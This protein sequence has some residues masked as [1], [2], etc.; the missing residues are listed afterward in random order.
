E[1]LYVAQGKSGFEAYDAASVGNKGFS[2]PIITAPF[3][4]LGHDTQI[5]TKDATCVALPTNQP[6]H[7]P[8]NAGDLMRVANEEQAFHPIYHYAVITDSVE[9]LILTNVDTLADGD[10]RHHRL[11]RAVTWNEG[12]VL[13]GARH[14]S[15]GGYYAYV[16]ADRGLVIV[17]LDDP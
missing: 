10:Q 1:Y 4:P 9:G 7:P 17:N 12:G 2:Q 14:V 13:N 6:I 16:I 8:R 5:G 3:S 11:E 15:L